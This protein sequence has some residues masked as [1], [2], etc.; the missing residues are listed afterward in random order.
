[1]MEVLTQREREIAILLIR[2]TTTNKEL[3]RELGIRSPTV[4]THLTNIYR[5][6]GVCN[7]TELVV[8]VMMEVQ[9]SNDV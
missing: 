7:R 4:Q 5:K 6:T 9:R 2:G 8:M 1:M 3:S